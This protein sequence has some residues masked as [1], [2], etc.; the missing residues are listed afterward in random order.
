[1]AKI[2]AMRGGSMETQPCVLLMVAVQKIRLLGLKLSR[3]VV[4]KLS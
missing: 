2:M 4:C 1:M 3:V